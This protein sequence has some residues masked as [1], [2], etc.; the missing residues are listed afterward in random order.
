VKEQFNPV[1]N[2]SDPMA[3]RKEG[4]KETTLMFLSNVPQNTIGRGNKTTT[5]DS[6][7]IA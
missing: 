3:I 1:N 5:P 7:G 2:V 4:A 6:G